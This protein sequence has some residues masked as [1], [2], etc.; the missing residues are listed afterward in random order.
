MWHWMINKYFIT[1]PTGD[2]IENQAIKSVFGSH[3]NN[4]AVSSTKGATG[5][6]LGAAGALEAI[7]TVLAC[8]HVS[9]NKLNYLPC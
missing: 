7:F 1:S 9:D 4:L 8:Q 3:A 6:L 2:E 5:H